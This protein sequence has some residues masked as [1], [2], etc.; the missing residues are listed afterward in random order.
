MKTKILIPA[1]LLVFSLSAII[2]VSCTKDDNGSISAADLSAAQEDTYADALYEEVDNMVS[3]ELSSLDKNGYQSTKKSGLA[4]ACYT[5][6]IDHPDSLTFPKVVTID[7]GEG[8][9]VVFNGDSIVRKGKIIITQTGRWFLKNSQHSVTLQDFYIND[10]KVEGTRTW[11][12]LG[13]NEK[14]HLEL[15]IVLTG[16]KITFNDTAFMTREADHKREIIRRLNSQNDTII[17]TGNAS[18]TN[19]LGQTY[20][21]EITSPLVMVHCSEYNWRWV[22]VDGSVQLTNSETGVLTIDYTGSGC[23]GEVTVNKDGV[24]RDFTFKYKR[25]GQKG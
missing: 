14:N 9:L 15:G 21:R 7:Y 1:L 17:V 5:V 20:N 13:Y 12:N 11:T 22:I 3:D 16:G 24:K 10:I 18:G 23:T 6:T 25:S 4:D 19:V 8:C 2:A